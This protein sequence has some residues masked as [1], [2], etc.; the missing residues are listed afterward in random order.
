MAAVTAAHQ[1][2]PPEFVQ[3]VRELEARAGTPMV[4][5][6]EAT[7]TATQAAALITDPSGS[8]WGTMSAAEAEE[9]RVASP[10]HLAVPQTSS[11]VP[12]V[13]L[14]PWVKWALGLTAV[15]LVG[16]GAYYAWSR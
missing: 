11:T 3:H 6:H 8:G 10:T 16:G 1:G 14:Q 7:L 2:A 15:V 5:V 9:L 13:P 12:R 4:L